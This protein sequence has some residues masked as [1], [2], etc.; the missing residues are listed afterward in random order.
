MK[1]LHVQSFLQNFSAPVFFLSDQ[2]P[3]W[4]H[5]SVQYKAVQ[6][7]SIVRVS[8]AVGWYT[9]NQRKII[10]KKLWKYKTKLKHNKNLSIWNNT[11]NMCQSTSDTWGSIHIPKLFRLGRACVLEIL[12]NKYE[13]LSQWTI[14]EA[15]FK[16]ALSSEWS[17]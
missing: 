1:V 11:C 16:T 3:Q 17:V 10:K 2:T 12:K 9:K 7:C 8:S 15:V 13:L 6:P 5:L 4:Y 14:Y